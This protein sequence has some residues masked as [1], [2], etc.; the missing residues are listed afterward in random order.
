MTTTDKIHDWTVNFIVILATAI[1]VTFSVV[2]YHVTI[3]R[4]E[5]PHVI[6]HEAGTGKQAIILV[7]DI[8]WIRVNFL[9]G[10]TQIGLIAGKT[11][12][13]I[14]SEQEVRDAM[15][16]SLREYGQIE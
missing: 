9:S 3:D 16:E 15:E 10:N 5:N 11:L 2:V 7:E 6:V 4:I 13:I 12:E 14:E 1:A 8:I